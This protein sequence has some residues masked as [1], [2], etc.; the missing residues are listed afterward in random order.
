MSYSSIM[1][2]SHLHFVG[3][4]LRA[5]LNGLSQAWAICTVNLIV[6][7]IPLCIEDKSKGSGLQKHMET[8]FGHR[9]D[10][11]FT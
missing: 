9:H 4:P 5:F 6:S 3:C 7:H 11:I 10:V 2:Y 8:R 1:G